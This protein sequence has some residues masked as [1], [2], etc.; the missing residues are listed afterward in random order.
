MGELDHYRIR[1]KLYGRRL[2]GFLRDQENHVGYV[3]QK[4]YLIKITSRSTFWCSNC[5]T[6]EI[7][8]Y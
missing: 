1:E 7:S 8:K 2:M 4:L 3:E 6:I 5:Q